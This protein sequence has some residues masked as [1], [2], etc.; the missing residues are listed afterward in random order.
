MDRRA[1]QAR[2]IHSAINDILFE[3]WDPIGMNEALP[4]DE[5]EAYV[6]DVYR[7]LVNGKSEAGLVQLLTT[8]E[9]ERIGL[10]ASLEQKTEAARRLR[11]LDIKLS[12][13]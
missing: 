2:Q 4:R 1:R 9:N 11:A 8:M 5:Y 10:R 12:E 3:Y 6:A 7:A 13:Q